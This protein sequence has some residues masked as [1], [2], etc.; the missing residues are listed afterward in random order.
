MSGVGGEGLFCL[1]SIPNPI[2]KYCAP[3]T[4]VTVIL[5]L[6]AYHSYDWPL[7][8]FHL[9]GHLESRILA[10][11]S[12]FESYCLTMAFYVKVIIYPPFVR[13]KTSLYVKLYT[14]LVVFVLT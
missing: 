11:S 2:Q 1:K 3:P 8:I 6:L 12:L 9:F 7:F 13:T 5:N 10:G 4:N 14:K